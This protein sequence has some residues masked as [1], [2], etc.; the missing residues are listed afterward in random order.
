MKVISICLLLFIGLGSYSQQYSDNKGHFI[1]KIYQQ[2]NILQNKALDTP[3]TSDP[4]DQLVTYKNPVLKI[5][6]GLGYRFNTTSTADPYISPVDTTLQFQKLPSSAFVISAT[7]VFELGKRIEHKVLKYE[8]GRARLFS[9]QAY[10]EKMSDANA[11]KTFSGID[12]DKVSHWVLL[13]SLNLV[14][15]DNNGASFNKV[16]DG[17]LGLG[18]RVSEGIHLGL[19]AEYTNVRQLRSS[20]ANN[21]EDKPI[22]INNDKLATLN[23]E[24]NNFF[25]NKPVVSIALKLVVSLSGKATNSL[26]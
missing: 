2:L 16:I 21:F 24:D 25:Y 11:F 14:D 23:R 13:A 19:M 15:I 12:T 26:E 1:N 7:L 9:P 6:L 18:Y 22:I 20:I 3:E 8:K 17:G 10:N 4:P 5:G